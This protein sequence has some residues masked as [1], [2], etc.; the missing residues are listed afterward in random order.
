M[1]STLELCIVVAEYDLFCLLVPDC[2]S[3]LAGNTSAHWRRGDSEATASRAARNT[4]SAE[5]VR[6]KARRP[7][8]H[9]NCPGADSLPIMRGM[10]A[11]T[12]G[13]DDSCGVPGGA[14]RL[15]RGAGGGAPKRSPPLGAKDKG[16]RSIT[17]AG[18]SRHVRARCL[19]AARQTPASSFRPS[20]RSQ[21]TRTASRGFDTASPWTRNR[22][23]DVSTHACTDRSPR[24]DLGLAVGL[25]AWRERGA[26]DRWEVAVGRRPAMSSASPSPPTPGEP[27]SEQGPCQ[28]PACGEASQRSGTNESSGDG[29]CRVRSRR[30]SGLRADISPAPFEVVDDVLRDRFDQVCMVLRHLRTR[31]RIRKR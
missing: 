11:R 9:R 3:P 17:R 25:G 13:G 12:H 7:P 19:T 15:A 29:Q 8:G 24:A 26:G 28:Y 16:H 27:G 18:A 30:L 14:R 6:S 20:P 2:A 5:V 23:S 10:D 1:I 31:R 21:R 22:P 4:N